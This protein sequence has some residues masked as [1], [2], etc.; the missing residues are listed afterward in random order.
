MKRLILV[1]I[2]ILLAGCTTTKYI[3]RVHTEYRHSTDTLLQHDSVLK[4][5]SVVIRI[6]GDTVYNDRWHTV[7]KSNIVY[8]LRT[9]TLCR[10]DSVDKP[11]YIEKKQS[12]A[13]KVKSGVAGVI[14]AGFILLIFGFVISIIKKKI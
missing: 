8:R 4:W 12:L 2:I 11:V 5:D 1:F 3:D 14:I 9:D 10:T 7:Y 6:Q 13:E